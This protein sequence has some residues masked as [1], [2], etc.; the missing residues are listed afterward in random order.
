M[1]WKER[2]TNT[3]CR[4]LRI[5]DNRIATHTDHVP[6]T[7]DN[8]SVDED[9]PD[10]LRLRVQHDFADGVET[11]GEVHRAR[12]ENDQVGLLPRGQRTYLVRHVQERRAIDRGHA[13]TLVTVGATSG[14]RD[15]ARCKPSAAPTR[16]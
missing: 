8:L 15:V 13:K 1:A 7:F 12:I 2:P 4:S 9:P 14:R 3:I 16:S 6:S 10:V 5:P 11:W